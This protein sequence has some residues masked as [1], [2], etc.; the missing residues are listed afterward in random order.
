MKTIFTLTLLAIPFLATAQTKVIEKPMV[1]SKSVYTDGISIERIEIKKDTTR[2][3]MSAFLP[4]EG[5]KA[6]IVGDTYIVVKEQRLPLLKAEGIV[7]DS[8]FVAPSAEDPYKK[9]TLCFPEI[10]KD[11]ESFDFIESDCP[12]CF[13][14]WNIS[15]TDSLSA[16]IRAQKES[17]EIAIAEASTIID[18][19]TYLED[20]LFMIGN[21][22]I[23][24]RIVGY[25]NGVF[26]GDDT[27]V[28]FYI[29]NPFTSKYESYSASILEDGTFETTLPL[30]LK[31]QTVSIKIKPLFY[32]N[33]IARCGGTEELVVALYPKVG[34]DGS[35]NPVSTMHYA[36][37]NA[38]INNCLAKD[39]QIHLINDILK[40]RG[41]TASEYKEYVYS[42]GKKYEE[43]VAQM[44]VPTKVKEYLI[45]DSKGWMGYFL[46]MRDH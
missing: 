25:H 26:G 12:Q 38:D 8:Y 17:E 2:L 46:L 35:Q 36:G 13:K 10:D 44:N 19:G 24:G 30:V 5:N 34:I 45:Y 22:T 43:K 6:C 11:I 16:K 14:M 39:I 40:F 4:G 32:T 31:D 42:L 15:L 41:M 23:K 28:L 33:F 18:D 7:L 9:F 37:D 27:P 1:G 20:P 21:T 3:Y 29:N